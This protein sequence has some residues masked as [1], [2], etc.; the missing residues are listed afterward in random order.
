MNLQIKTH[1]K[2]KSIISKLN[3]WKNTQY[4]HYSN[5]IANVLSLK[6]MKNKCLILIHLFLSLYSQSSAN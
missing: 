4:L 6:Q 2:A 5:D 1:F 3:I